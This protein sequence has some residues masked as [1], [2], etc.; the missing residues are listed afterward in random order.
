[1]NCNL[2]ANH[3][4]FPGILHFRNIDLYICPPGGINMSKNLKKTKY[5]RS[6]S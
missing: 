4:M 1:M 5:H 3:E 2:V 6:C